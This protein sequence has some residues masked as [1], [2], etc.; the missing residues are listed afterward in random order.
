MA[1]ENS[2]SDLEDFLYTY[3]AHELDA[4]AQNCADEPRVFAVV[5]SAVLAALMRFVSV[6]S[7]TI[8]P[9]QTAASRSSLLTTRSRWRIRCSNRSKT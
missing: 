9:L 6:S 1:L 2:R 4:L 5:P 8:R 3:G 7:D